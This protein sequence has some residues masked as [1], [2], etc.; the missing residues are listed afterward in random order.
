MVSPFV[1]Y[2]VV[3]GTA[4]AALGGV[5]AARRW[6]DTWGIEPDEAARS[7]AGD[8]IVAAASGV[9]TRG[10]TIDAP[11]D[12]VWPWLVQMGFGRAGWYSY[13][14]LD[15][16]GRSA[17]EIVA[18]WQSLA[19]GD[20]VQTDPGGGFEVRVLEPERALVLY[21][22]S[23]MVAARAKDVGEAIRAAGAPGL[24]ASGRFLATATPPDFAASWAF[25][26]EPRE[27]GQTRLIERFRIGFEAVTPVTQLLG[28]A[29]RFG[30]FV[31]MR[32]QMLGIR[33]RAERLARQ[34]PAEHWMVTVATNGK[35][36]IVPEPVGAI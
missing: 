29:V 20:T 24:A 28:P 32:K 10:I 22:D 23:A 18:A 7:L 19:V 35:A 6:R 1:R 25:V 15:M 8:D 33:D 31:M 13:D 30:L 27:H 5:V 26:L 34:T 4:A 36:S 3:G 11:P 17:D 12:E 2:A 9:E 16:D 21:S 14:R